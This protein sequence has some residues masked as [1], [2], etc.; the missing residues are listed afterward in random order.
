MMMFEN[1]ISDEVPRTRIVF[2][3]LPKVF[4]FTGSSSNVFEITKIFFN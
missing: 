2:V 1:F 3:P 4:A